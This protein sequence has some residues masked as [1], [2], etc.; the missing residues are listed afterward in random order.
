[1]I[2][3][4]RL[5]SF[6]RLQ[7]QKSHVGLDP[8][9]LGLRHDNPAKRLDKDKHRYQDHLLDTQADGSTSGAD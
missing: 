5:N 7:C 6:V 3:L 2:H 4:S 8:A 9:T 1:M